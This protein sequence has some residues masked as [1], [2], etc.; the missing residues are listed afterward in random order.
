MEIWLIGNYFT[1]YYFFEL[2]GSQ[3]VKE[4]LSFSVMTTI[5]SHSTSCRSQQRNTTRRTKKVALFQT[6]SAKGFESSTTV[7][8]REE[9][10]LFCP[11]RLQN[12]RCILYE[13]VSQKEGCVLCAR[14][15]CVWV[16]LMCTCVLYLGV[17]C[18]WVCLVCT[19]VLYLGVSCVHMCPV[20][21]YVLC[22][23]V[24]CVCKQARHFCRSQ[25]RNRWTTKRHLEYLW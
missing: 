14:V 25:Q 7:I 15:S 16:C 17:S 18:V 24:S 1:W 3:L 6:S 8:K 5:C 2:T 20:F 9:T 13:V 23:G 19:C 4:R 21:G 12:C 10:H 22:L 11:K